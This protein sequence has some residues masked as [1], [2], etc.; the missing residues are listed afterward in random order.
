MNI[1]A[2][3]GKLQNISS[4]LTPTILPRIKSFTNH[5]QKQI[6]EACES[7]DIKTIKEF[8]HANQS[9]KNGN[10]TVVDML[11][12]HY[13]GAEGQIPL[14]A[15][16]GK[17]LGGIFT[18]LT[19]HSQKGLYDC[20]SKLSNESIKSNPEKISAVQAGIDFIRNSSEIADV[21]KLKLLTSKSD[22]LTANQKNAMEYFQK[23]IL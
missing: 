18:Y 4:E 13:A 19:S 5:T 7:G 23:H 3:T 21:D 12:S 1:C 22:F 6:F 8:I 2:V 20:L 11:T 16:N 10:E 15:A 9:M 17:M 14:N